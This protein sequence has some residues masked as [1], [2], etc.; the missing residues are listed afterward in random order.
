[1]KV[2][3]AGAGIGGLT[4]AL[5]LAQSGHTVSIFEQ[6]SEFAE[7]GAGIQCGAN[8][9]HV[10]RSLGLSSALESI[11]VRPER[12]DFRDFKTGARLHC[13]PL[14]DSYQ[15]KYGAPYLHLH[16]A[17]LHSILLKALRNETAV[18]VSLN[19]RVSSYVEFGES[20]CINLQDGRKFEGDCLVAADGVHSLIRTQ[21]LGVSRPRYTGNVAWRGVVPVSRLPENWM[22]TVVTNFVGPKK[23]MVLYY[24]RNRQFAN[25]VGVVERPDAHSDSWVT[26]APWQELKDDFSGWHESVQDIVRAMDKDQ[27]YRWGLFNHSPFPNWSSQLVTLMGDAAHSTLPFMASGAAMAIEDARIF[28]RALDQEPTV[29]QALQC[30]QRNRL[31]R[32]AQIQNDSSRAGALYH[33]ESSLMRKAAF[34]ALK[35]VSAKKEAFLPSYNAN[36]IHLI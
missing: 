25:F 8:A 29:P 18:E 28:Q 10:L 5:C 14:G 31:S 27:C 12:I 32:T 26:Q 34:T 6:A 13:M 22:D 4:A 20:I 7:V 17:D 21:L 33:F 24:L 30:Y 23:H 9:L 15:E 3:I 1:V 36:T 16:R 35:L 11:A 2:L 19:S